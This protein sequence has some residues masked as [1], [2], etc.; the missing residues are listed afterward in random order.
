MI[1]HTEIHIKTSYK[2]SETQNKTWR[3]IQL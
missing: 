2:T 3:N 1:K